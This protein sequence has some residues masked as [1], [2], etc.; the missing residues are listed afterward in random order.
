MIKFSILL[1]VFSLA[2]FQSYGQT[3][4]D[5]KPIISKNCAS[6]H[7]DGGAMFS[8]TRYS[9]VK[10]NAGS[11]KADVSSGRMPPWPPDATYR[12][13]IHER[14][15]STADKNALISWIDAN[16]PAGDT[17]LA[18]PTPVFKKSEL[19]GTPDL[20]IKTPKITSA[21]SSQDQYICVNVPAGIAQD[22]IVRAYEFIPGNPA[23]IHHAVISIDTT[24]NAVNDLSGGCFNF[25]GQVVLGEF[26]PGTGPTVFPGV[27]PMKLGMRL[28]AGSKI[29]F[30]MH[31]PAG[32]AGEEDSSEFHIFFYPL[33][34][35]NVRPMI[36]ETV[37]QNWVFNV[38]ANTVVDA[39]AY[40][41]KNGLGQPLPLPIDVSVYAALG[42]SHN[43]CTSILNYAF[44]GA[45]T[46]P[47]LKIPN[48]DFHWQGVY[49]YP[50]M[51]KLPKGYV[52]YGKH[53]FDNT[54]NN[55]RTP[56]HNKAVK[57]GPFTADE[58]L[59]DSYIYTAYVTGDENVDIAAM[60]ATDPLFTPSSISTIDKTLT[61]VCVYPNPSS[62]SVTINYSLLNAQYVQ[63]W[64]HNAQGQMVNKIQS[65]IEASGNHSQIWDGN[66]I[67]GNRVSPGTYFFKIQAGLNE[68]TGSI[69]IE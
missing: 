15:L 11:I 63:V 52:V 53:R 60:L 20:I 38:P 21:S 8:L 30:Q 19:Y 62:G 46:I 42:H 36:F 58:M 6:C 18:P 22:R 5:I 65:K 51:L 28:K 9:E 55:P 31:I 61:K 23:I 68:K 57:P 41:P 50:K 56:N 37:L 14:I 64:I 67:E 44:K 13:Y 26:A 45:D 49:T 2:V 47:L 3:Y 34:E 40:F 10:A 4:K 59:F 48:W 69:V 7:R 16:T 24:G 66:N 43:T 35:P 39:E 27:A 54:I 1:L 17:T 12:K 25:Q 29:S 33:N 32:T